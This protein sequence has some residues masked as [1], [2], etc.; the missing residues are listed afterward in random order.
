MTHLLRE[1]LKAVE[2]PWPVVL[3]QRSVN[4]LQTLLGAGINT[5]WHQHYEGGRREGGGGKGE[6]EEQGKEVKEEEEEEEEE[7][8][9]KEKDEEEEDEEEMVWIAYKQ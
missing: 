3:E 2:E 1:C 9:E 8:E 7:D 5:D 4:P 6:G